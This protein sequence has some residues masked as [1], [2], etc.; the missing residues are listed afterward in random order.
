MSETTPNAD[1]TPTMPSPEGGVATE[2]P[3]AA[4]PQVAPAGVRDR[5]GCMQRGARGCALY[6]LLPAMVLALGWFCWG[7]ANEWVRGREAKERVAEAV[8][9]LN[10]ARER[11][12]GQHS[13]DDTIRLMREIDR[14]L[15]VDS[16][17]YFEYLQQTAMKPGL[18]K[19]EV[20]AEVLDARTRLM[21]R[22][23]ELYMT[24]ESEEEKQDLFDEYRYSLDS[25]GEFATEAVKLGSGIGIVGETR[26]NQRSRE[27]EARAKERADA[28]ARIREQRLAF[29]EELNAYAQ[30]YSV[31][32]QKW[33]AFCRERDR[34]WLYLA[35]GRWEEAEAAADEAL[36]KSP[37]DREALL[38]RAWAATEQIR[39]QAPG[40]NASRAAEVEASLAHVE[41]R[42]ADFDAP[43]AVLRAMLAAHAGDTQRARDQLAFAATRYPD[44][45]ERF[46][47]LND[48]YEMRGYLQDSAEGSRILETYHG[49]VLGAGYFST[50]LQR[51]RLGLADGGL[52]GDR[53]AAFVRDVRKRRVAESAADATALA[54]IREAGQKAVAAIPKPGVLQQF[55]ASGRAMADYSR[56]V[57]NAQRP[58]EEQWEHHTAM[59]ELNLFQVDMAYIAAQLPFAELEGVE[60]RGTFV[61]GEPAVA[62][63][64]RHS[65]DVPIENVSLIAGIRFTDM[66]VGEHR[67]FFVPESV[68]TLPPGEWVPVGTAQVAYELQSLAKTAEDA[69]PSGNHA[70]LVT[71]T[72]LFR[73]P[74]TLEEIAPAKPAPKGK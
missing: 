31:Y 42:T 22:M 11:A 30:V 3:P 23:T 63:A 41:A 13:I 10:A 20:A 35:D 1:H 25:L 55:F 43:I 9:K 19:Y 70:V 59:A 37:G 18:D 58:F 8:A 28:L 16:G 24:L 64:V 72:G 68:P 38:L 54:T 50:D 74:L 26:L 17:D 15:T 40:D 5:K 47:R 52:A 71:D 32:M 49:M 7:W 53:T 48:L 36:A 62:F 65:V 51:M 29:I 46:H 21:E 6:A 39:A 73:V 44:A 67:Y 57:A 45:R 14:M 2:P 61:A 56:R 34:A 27:S 12:K 60:A 69:I 4:A 33:D 66:A